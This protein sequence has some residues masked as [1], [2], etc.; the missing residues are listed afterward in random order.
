MTRTTTTIAILATACMA[1]PMGATAAAAARSSCAPTAEAAALPRHAFADLRSAA[2]DL[3]RQ[4]PHGTARDLRAAAVDLERLRNGGV[5]PPG[6]RLQ[7]DI[8]TLQGAALDAD[9]GTLRSP[10]RL[11]ARLMPVAI[12]LAGYELRLAARNWTH[13]RCIQS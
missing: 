7:E 10:W 2:R 6:G 3:G 1:S 13:Q 9:G 8:L 12:H 11:D 5:V 4:H